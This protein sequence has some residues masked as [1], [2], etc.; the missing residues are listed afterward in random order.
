MKREKPYTCELCGKT[1]NKVELFIGG[2]FLYL[3]QKCADIGDKAIKAH[4]KS[5]VS[6]EYGVVYLANELIEAEKE[7]HSSNKLET[8]K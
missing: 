6:M 7:L 3:H 8:E 5:L 4:L 1:D 2:P